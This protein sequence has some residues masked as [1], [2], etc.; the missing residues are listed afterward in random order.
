[1]ENGHSDADFASLDILL[2]DIDAC[3]DELAEVVELIKKR[4]A[5][6]YTSFILNPEDLD[7][8]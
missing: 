8:Q 2:A 6:D 3:L 5:E 7:V 4:S 1:M